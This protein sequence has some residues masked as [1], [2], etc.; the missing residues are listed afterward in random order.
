MAEWIES[1][2]LEAMTSNRGRSGFAALSAQVG[3]SFCTRGSHPR[4]FSTKAES[5]LA[6]VVQ[7][8][9]ILNL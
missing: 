1:W 7:L 6:A 4:I 2:D 8:F 9:Q 5:I 3:W